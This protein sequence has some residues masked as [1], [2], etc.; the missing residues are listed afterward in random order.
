[1]DILAILATTVGVF[2]G[3]S[4]VPQA[5]KI[6]QRKSVRDISLTTYVIVEVGSLI[7]IL[8]GL[9]IKNYPI[10]IPNVL[11]F[12]ATGLVLIGYLLYRKAEK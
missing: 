8:Y 11:G 10:V 1:M 12:L 6:F 2:L 5:I 7:W 3:L 4:N 9:E